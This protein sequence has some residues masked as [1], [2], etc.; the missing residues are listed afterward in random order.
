MEKFSLLYVDDEESNLRIF[1][2]TFR[3][4]F[5]VFTAK[6]A[7][8]GIEIL[9]KQNIDLVLSDQRM[10]EMTGVEFLKYSLEKH[11]KPNRI[12]VTG[13]TDLEAIENA[14]NNAHIFQY[15][16]KPWNEKHLLKVIE[17]ALRIYMLENENEK[18]KFELIKAK[19][20]AEASDRLKTEFINNMSH[21]IRTPM[22]G[23]IGF[24]GLLDRK[25]LKDDKKSEYIG[26][27][28]S[29]GKRLLKII[30]NILEISQLKTKQI[31]AVGE[32]VCV[33]NICDDLY[34]IFSMTANQNNLQF[35]LHKKLSKQQST[36]FSDGIKI[37]S[38][39][40]QLLENAFKFTKQG[41]IDFGC[42]LSNNELVLRVKDTGIGVPHEI[43]KTIFD[44]FVR[45]HKDQ[46]EV[47]GGLGLGLS[48]AKEYAEILGGRIELISEPGKG[49]EFMAIIPYKPYDIDLM[50]DKRLVNNEVKTSAKNETYTILIAEDD[51]TNF[52]YLQ[53]ILTSDLKKECKILHAENGLEAVNMCK[54]NRDIDLVL[55]DIKMPVLNGF[56]ATKQIKE[57]N[58]KLPVIVQTAYVTAEGETMAFDHG[59]DGFLTKPLDENELLESIYEYL[60]QKKSEG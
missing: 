10:P 2:N 45:G 59:C 25:N 18:Q 24:S 40:S 56:N 15:I 50:E 38:I 28:K 46:E 1:K 6:S 17:D 47:V 12:L 11:P 33:N 20:K 35:N 48:I 16:Q 49:S 8:E 34:A 55:M 29:C 5:N 57:I 39:L 42:E 51:I 9:D 27:I 26:L 7:K 23:I 31:E 44:Q 54:E 53:S 32:K 58:P 21:E 43:H 41:Q 22:N 19:E 4:K 36:I 14:I 37:S 60:K 52:L 13:Y 30:D 3:R